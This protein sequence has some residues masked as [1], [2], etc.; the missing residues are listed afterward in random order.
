MP[1]KTTAKKS[2]R[3]IMEDFFFY[4]NYQEIIFFEDFISEIVPAIA[5][6][7]SSDLPRNF[8]EQLRCEVENYDIE[9]FEQIQS[10]LLKGKW[11]RDMVKR[12][13]PKP[14]S[15]Q[16]CSDWVEYWIKN[17][18]QNLEKSYRGLCEEALL[19]EYLTSRKLAETLKIFENVNQTLIKNGIDL[20]V[21]HK[22]IEK[23]HRSYFSQTVPST[24]VTI[25]EN[26][27]SV[28]SKTFSA[29]NN[30]QIMEK[31]ADVLPPI[32]VGTLQ[33]FK[34]VLGWGG[35]SID[36]PICNISNTAFGAFD[37]DRKD[38]EN[39]IGQRYKNLQLRCK[40]SQEAIPQD[41]LKIISKKRKM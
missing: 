24:L 30:T 12:L 2:A 3:C 10:I 4:H 37:I 32:V 7:G 34:D 27:P 22:K 29:L 35:A 39:R 11:T 16:L 14:H 1:Q 20:I 25:Y 28:N 17:D 8:E 38:F 15:T 9:T 18:L 31:A 33:A 36:L 5:Q 26:S 40:I 41:N 13:A 23:N 19:G 21:W 6:F